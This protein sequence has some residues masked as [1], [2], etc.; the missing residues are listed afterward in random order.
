MTVA[1]GSDVRAV[2]RR[3]EARPEGVFRG[4]RL[5]PGVDFDRLL[6][7]VQR[8]GVVSSYQRPDRGFSLIAVGEAGRAELPPG[9]GAAALRAGAAELL[10]APG[11]SDAE[12]LRPRLLGGFSFRAT[13]L[14][15]PSTPSPAE[16]SPVVPWEGFGQGALVLPE[17][18]CV[19]DD[20]ETGVVLA[21]GVPAT[22]LAGFLS[23]LAAADGGAPGGART[24]GEGNGARVAFD[25]DAE[26][27]LGSVARVASEVRAGLYEKAVL[28]TCREL[29]SGRP[30][31]QGGALRRLRDGYG[32]CHLFSVTRGEATFFGASPELLVSLRKG[33]MRALGLAGSARRGSDAGDDERRGRELQASAK[34]RIEH[35]IVVRAIREALLPA[36]RWL[37]APNQPGLLRLR[38]IQ[39]L[40]TE[41]RGEVW[42]G[43]DVLDL[44]ERLHPTPAV[45][46]WPTERALRVIADHERFDRGWYGGPVGWLDAAGDGEF[47]VALRSALVRGE[48]AWLFAGA[49]IMGDSEP[50]DELAEVELKFRPLAEALGLAPAGENAGA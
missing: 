1:S 38:N 16:E 48:R 20:G 18:L 14:D 39:H 26:R 2:A 7:D 12:A 45:G 40:A 47:A 11:E 44:V 4:L 32:D 29:A 35:E 21:P 8:W 33:A 23:D 46:G 42:P 10:G 27:W 37:R 31:D 9:G 34:D 36:S 49:G 41:V 19:R 22:R 6:D 17:I 13:A 15:L 50:A 3:A 25:V 28:A 43:A 24:A 30:I 5:P